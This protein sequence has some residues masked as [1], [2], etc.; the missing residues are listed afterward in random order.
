M[1]LSTSQTGIRTSEKPTPWS[2]PRASHE[3]APAVQQ[4][5][6]RL[7][8]TSSEITLQNITWERCLPGVRRLPTMRLA[9]PAGEVH[10]PSEVMRMHEHT[11]P[12]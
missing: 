10:S 9:I 6:R 1:Q 7:V 3:D 5:S 11:A 2:P 12:A 4:V 8:S